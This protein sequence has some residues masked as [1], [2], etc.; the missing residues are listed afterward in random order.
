MG[1]VCACFSRSCRPLWPLF[2]IL[3]ALPLLLDCSE[4]S[5][6]VVGKMYPRGNHWAVG[7]LM[8]KKSLPV[9]Q[10]TNSD[11]ITSSE[12]ARVTEMD[13][14]Q[15]LL[16]ALMLPKNPQRDKKPKTAEN[17]LAEEA[18]YLREVSNL[19]LLALKLRDEDSV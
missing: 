1:G 6:A 13:R 17:L 3:A 19:L 15:G 12:T 4:T 10:E 16:E 9:V 7:H 8:G 2:I 14:Y 11:Y 18:K 5:A